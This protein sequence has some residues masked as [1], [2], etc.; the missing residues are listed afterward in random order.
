MGWF[1]EQIKL[2]KKKDHDAFDRTF[3]RIACAVTGNKKALSGLGA[4]ERAQNAV[5]EI[6][7]Y[8][9]TDSVE[10]PP[11]IDT[12]EKRLEYA[13]NRSGIMYRTVELEE[14]WYKDAFGAML[15][16]RKEDHEPVALLPFGLSHYRYYDNEKGEYSLVSEKS[17][18]LFEKEAYAFYRSF[19]L[20]K[21]RLI[22]LARYILGILEPSDYILVVLATLIVTL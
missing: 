15:G 1:D 14:G 5:D 10:I 16:F 9:H 20:K 3:L 13:L 19:P 18:E 6:L 2:R 11:K 22:D 21:L 8:Y 4:E 12:P 17:E 7:S